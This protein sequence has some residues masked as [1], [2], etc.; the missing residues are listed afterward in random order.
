MKTMY[1]QGRVAMVQ[2]VS[3][4]NNNGSHFRGRDIWFMGGG[5]DDYFD[6]GWLG[7]YL[8]DE[9]SPEQYPDDFPNTE[10]P[11]PLALEMGSDVSLIFHQSGNIPTSISIDNPVSFFNLVDELEGFDDLEILFESRTLQGQGGLPRIQPFQYIRRMKSE[12]HRERAARHRAHQLVAPSIRPCYALEVFEDRVRV[13]AVVEQRGD[14]HRPAGFR[15]DL[16]EERNRRMASL[17]EHENAAAVLRTGLAQRAGE[18]A[19]L[20]IVGEP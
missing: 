9:Y 3:Y 15:G 14:H 1:D 19:Q 16:L 6:S 17:G 7:R 10:M 13:G 12:I 11:D 18:D 2:G 4:K 8:Q 5:S 20:R